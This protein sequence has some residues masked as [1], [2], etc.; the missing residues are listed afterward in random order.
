MRFQV[1]HDRRWERALPHFD[2]RICPFCGAL[3]FRAEGQK[4]HQADHEQLLQL[5]E[6]VRERCGITEDDD[7][8][9]AWTAEVTGGRDALED[10]DDG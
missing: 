6:L 4:K 8:Q 1:I 10:D 5:M 7:G 3:V 2:V 9:W